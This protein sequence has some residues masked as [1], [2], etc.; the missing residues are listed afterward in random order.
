MNQPQDN[1]N[2]TR[3]L[4]GQQHQKPQP[5]V[6]NQLR[7]LFTSNYCPDFPETL[8]LAER[9]AEAFLNLAGLAESDQP[10]P[11]ELITGLPRIKVVFEPISESGMSQFVGNTWLIV[12]NSRDHRL[13]QRFTLAHE[14]KHILD[15]HDSRLLYSGRHWLSDAARTDDAHQQRERAADHFAGC[16][17]MPRARVERSW[18]DGVLTAEDLA[19]HFDVSTAAVKVRLEQLGLVRPRWMCTRGLPSLDKQTLHITTRETI[20]KMRQLRSATQPERPER[21]GQPPLPRYVWP[22]TITAP[23]QVATRKMERLA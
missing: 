1:Q 13:R 2:E 21:A 7:G 6:L 4:H 19:R 10:V 23:S 3:R 11:A 5:S 12:L 20:A 15:H 17:L 14:F 8:R 9:Q 16:L 22:R 18:A